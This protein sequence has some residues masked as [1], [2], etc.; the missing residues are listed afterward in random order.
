[1]LGRVRSRD[2]GHVAQVGILAL[3]LLSSMASVKLL[4]L[5]LDLSPSSLNWT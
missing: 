5:P 4:N 3:S 2:P 1:M